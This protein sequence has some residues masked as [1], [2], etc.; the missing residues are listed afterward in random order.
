MRR[1]LAALVADSLLALWQALIWL[2]CER[3]A[4]AGQAEQPFAELGELLVREFGFD[5]G[6]HGT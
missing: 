1:L 2:R 5:L 6:G 4:L 3:A